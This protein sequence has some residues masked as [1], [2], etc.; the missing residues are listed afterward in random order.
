MIDKKQKMTVRLSPAVIQYLELIARENGIRLST[1][2][3]SVL[4][5]YVSRVREET[6]YSYDDEISA[7]N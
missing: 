2:T 7:L 5:G 1:L 4:D 3:R 6:S